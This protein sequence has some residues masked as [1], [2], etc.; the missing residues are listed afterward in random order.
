MMK[1][2]AAVLVLVGLVGAV[3]WYSTEDASNANPVGQVS[4]MKYLDSNQSPPAEKTTPTNTMF[5]KTD[6]HI[7]DNTQMIS[8]SSSG[9]YILTI[10]KDWRTEI[11]TNSPGSVE[12]TN[13]YVFNKENKLVMIVQYPIAEI[14]YEASTA[15]DRGTVSTGIG[16]GGALERIVRLFPD[17]PTQ[18]I[19]HYSWSGGDDFWNNSFEIFV[20]FRS[21][22][23]A[24]TA[25]EHQS[26]TGVNL[27]LHSRADFD[28]WKP[29][30]EDIL[31]GVHR[32]Y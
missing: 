29:M 19:A 21:G 20:P 22:I 17:S 12:L 9:K 24:R 16:A 30:I 28:E 27:F 10:S 13:V 32:K 5:P 8:I 6:E 14:G 15:V 25:Q 1:P 3:Y 31:G 4:Q 26:G 18:G 7:L 2:L 11:R 23:Y